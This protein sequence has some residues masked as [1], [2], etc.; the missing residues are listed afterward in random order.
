MSQPPN[1]AGA[2][3][4]P[5]QVVSCLFAPDGRIVDDCPAWLRARVLAAHADGRSRWVQPVPAGKRP[6]SDRMAALS[7]VRL[8]ARQWIDRAADLEL[9][10]VFCIDADSVQ[11]WLALPKRLRIAG[12]PWPLL[13]QEWARSGDAAGDQRQP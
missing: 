6:R 4:T 3:L 2:D 13:P 1:Y 5:R 12:P 8:E 9:L 11:R 7:V 10:S